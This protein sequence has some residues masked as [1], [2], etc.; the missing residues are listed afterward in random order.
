MVQHKV[1]IWQIYS[2]IIKIILSYVKA[3]CCFW[4]CWLKPSAEIP[5]FRF[6][7]YLCWRD[8]WNLC[9]YCASFTDRKQSGSARIGGVGLV[10]KE[11]GAGGLCSPSE[12]GYIRENRGKRVY[13]GYR[14]WGAGVLWKVISMLQA[15]P[16]CAVWAFPGDG[17]WGSRGAGSAGCNWVNSVG[18][19]RAARGSPWHQERI[20]AF[21]KCRQWALW[22]SVHLR[23]G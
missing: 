15:S 18:R 14:S 4:W 19:S 21:D 11:A 10:L 3:M 9:R 16:P 22:S 23:E 6:G 5:K 2:E 17:W 7:E 13:W 1:H 8:F 12:I 20:P